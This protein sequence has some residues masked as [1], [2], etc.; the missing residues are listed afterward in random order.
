[1]LRKLIS[2]VGPD[3]A[4]RR[5]V[6]NCEMSVT[7]R[8][9]FLTRSRHVPISAHG[10]RRARP[11]GEIPGIDLKVK[12]SANFFKNGGP[13]RLFAVSRG[14]HAGCRYYFRQTVFCYADAIF[15]TASSD[16]SSPGESSSGLRV[17]IGRHAGHGRSFL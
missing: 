17:F 10:S 7:S 12:R 15:S 16:T 8:R 5:H 3:A 11:G 1:M 14:A 13:L 9:A 4:C 2:D 6:S